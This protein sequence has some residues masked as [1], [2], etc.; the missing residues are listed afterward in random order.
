MTHYRETDASDYVCAGILSQ[1][2]D[3]GILHF[4]AFYSNKISPTGRNYEMYD[5]ELLAI[6]RKLKE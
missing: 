6:I 3:H 1:P 2:D 5:K 4:V